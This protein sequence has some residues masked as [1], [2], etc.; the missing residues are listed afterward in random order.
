MQLRR[1]G[2][3]QGRDRNWADPALVER[4]DATTKADGQSPQWP[5]SLGTTDP[6]GCA[7]YLSACRRT[8]D[9]ES[10]V[11]SPLPNSSRLSTGAWPTIRSA[12]S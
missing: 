1:Q 3:A 4:D 2:S 6:L 7:G 9:M 5:M 11:T 12:R 10:S 8:N